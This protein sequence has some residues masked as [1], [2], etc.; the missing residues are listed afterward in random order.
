MPSKRQPPRR[1]AEPTVPELDAAAD[2][3]D[4]LA[5]DPGLIPGIFNYC[6]RWCERCAFTARC[7]S[8][9]LDRATRPPRAVGSG[10]RAGL[11]RAD[12]QSFWNDLA[13]SF[14]LARR[15]VERE[16]E[17]L[18]LDLDSADAL[19][20]AEREER[21]RRRAAARAGSALHQAGTVYW[22]TAQALL[23]R[24]RPALS[25]T[26]AELQAQVRLGAGHPE[27]IAAAIGDAL[28]VVEWYVFFID[29]KLQRAV[30][31][32]VDQERDGDH[33]FPGDADGSAKVAL[34]AI[35]RSIGAW[36]RLRDQF[37]AEADALLDLLV[38]LERLR[39]AVEREFPAARAFRRPGL[40]E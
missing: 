23:E 10:A 32:R 28:D 6:D 22:K 25:A 4:R 36:A 33:G 31:A 35:D 38:H 21:R 15:L 34:V 18:G 12:P 40:D 17:K 13:R 2:T 3:L 29:V 24:L 19:V 11:R 27:E 16:A 37:P 5:A 20:E 30:A 26:A 1:P 39:R 9:Q 14:A 8:F 7:L